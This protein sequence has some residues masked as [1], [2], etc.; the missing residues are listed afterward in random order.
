MNILDLSKITMRVMIS[1]VSVVCR[2]CLCLPFNFVY[3]YYVNLLGI[4]RIIGLYFMRHIF[5]N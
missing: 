1:F 3:K 4:M 5:M 2:T